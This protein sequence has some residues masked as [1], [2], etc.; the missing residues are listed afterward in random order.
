MQLRKC[1]KPADFDRDIVAV[2][3]AL[4]GEARR[5]YRDER[6]HDLAAEAVTRALEHR[7]SYD[8][9]PLLS[10]C[11]A[12]M[13]NLWINTASTLEP[14]ITVPLGDWDTAGGEAAD[15]RAI[16]GQLNELVTGATN[17]S[18]SVATLVEFASGRSVA[19]IA[20]ASGIPSGT[21]KRRVHDGRAMLAK[22]LAG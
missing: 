5:Y 19:E 6:A 15:Q 8:G 3:F 11:R 20:K 14:R 2:Y 7:G 16:V 17:R 10:W 13:R 12:I 22:L 1:Y 18:V 4:M 9:R 21:V